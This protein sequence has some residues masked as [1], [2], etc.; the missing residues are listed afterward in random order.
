MAFLYIAASTGGAD[1]LGRLEQLRL[2]D[3]QMGQLLRAALA[4]PQNACIGQVADNASD[5][6][7]VPHLP[8][9]GSVALCPHTRIDRQKKES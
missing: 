2:N 8:C 1:A 9:S 4:A 6:G 5:G 3:L 7:V